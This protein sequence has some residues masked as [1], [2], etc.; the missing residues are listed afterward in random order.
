MSKLKYFGKKVRF[1]GAAV[2][3]SVATQAFAI[4]APTA[5][6]SF[7]YK[8]YDVAVNDM[9]NGPLGFVAGL[10]LVG[11]SFTQLSQNWKLA[12]LGIVGGSGVLQ[13]DTIVST[14][15]ALI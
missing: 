8:I 2:T 9:L 15:G 12:A 6:T 3:A 4:T 5:T 11:Y 13:A 10:G 7:G 14:M 1:I